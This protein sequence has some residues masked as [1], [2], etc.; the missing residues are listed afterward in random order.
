[1]NIVLIGYRCCGKT[2]VGQDLARELGRYFVDSDRF[3][4]EKTGCPVEA[5]IRSMGWNHFRQLEKES[6]GEISR[7]DNLVVATGGGVVL[8]GENASRLKRNGWVVWLKGRAEVLRERMDRD[9]RLDKIRPPLTGNDPL[10]EIILVS[11]QRN[12]LYEQAANFTVDT[13]DFSI[14]DVAD[15]IIKAFRKNGGRKRSHGVR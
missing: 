12:A 1:M 5:I 4:E 8:D 10:E 3:V 6:V 7:K 15:S 2:T 14:K 13:S 9:Q 11:E